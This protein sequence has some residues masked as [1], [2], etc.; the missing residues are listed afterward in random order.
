MGDVGDST[1][2]LDAAHFGPLT[3]RHVDGCGILRDIARFGCFLVTAN[4]TLPGA[5]LPYLQVISIENYV[6]II[7]L[8][9]LQYRRVVD[10]LP[11]YVV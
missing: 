10:F 5:R 7:K 3:G 8:L 4:A 1:H 6:V 9:T 2:L 11:A